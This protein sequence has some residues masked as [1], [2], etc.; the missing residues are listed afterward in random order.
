MKENAIKK[1]NQMGSIGHIISIVGIVLNALGLF[2]LLAAIIVCIWLP[3]DLFNLK[4]IGGAE[5]LVNVDGLGMEFEDE[6]I[7]N[8]N[9]DAEAIMNG[10]TSSL[11]GWELTVNGQPVEESEL[12][13]T[14]MKMDKTTLNMG[15]VGPIGEFGVK[16]IIVICVYAMI[17]GIMM[18]ITIVFIA[19]LCKAFKNCKSPFEENV[20]KR[21]QHLAIALIPW[22]VITSVMESAMSTFVSRGGQINL[23]L[24]LDMGVVM[25]VVVIFI[26]AYIFKYGAILQQ[27][28][29]ETL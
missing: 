29:D 26:L 14:E 28:S 7:E 1:I 25:V 21:I 19:K 17:E 8:F 24:T 11:D 10:D 12:E 9:K 16:H 2:I 3:N 15:A 22:T 27:E 18:I 5:F 4:L 23:S 20:I 13:V 6:D